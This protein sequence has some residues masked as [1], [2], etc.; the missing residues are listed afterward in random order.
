MKK[1]QKGKYIGK[2]RN[3]YACPLCG[4]PYKLV[5][6]ETYTYSMTCDCAP[7]GVYVSIG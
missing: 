6:G 4:A 3:P 1:P 5:K 7:K 2:V